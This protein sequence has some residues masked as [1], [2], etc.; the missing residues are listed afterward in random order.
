[1]GLNH[2]HFARV[3]A[4]QCLRLQPAIVKNQGLDPWGPTS[5]WIWWFLRQL[6]FGG[7]LL[8]DFGWGGL[9][10]L[11]AFFEVCFCFVDQ[12]WHVETFFTTI[13]V[14]PT[15]FGLLVV[16][17]LF[18][19]WWFCRSFELITSFWLV[20]GCARRKIEV[21]RVYLHWLLVATQWL[22]MVIFIWVVEGLNFFRLLGRARVRPV[23]IISRGLHGLGSRLCA[24]LL[25]RSSGGSFHRSSF[26]WKRC[27]NYID[28]WVDWAFSTHRCLVELGL[29]RSLLGV[30]SP[31][32]LSLLL[33]STKS[34]CLIV[35]EACWVLPLRLVSSLVLNLIVVRGG[36]DPK[37][38]LFSLKYLVIGSLMRFVTLVQETVSLHW[39]VWLVHQIVKVVAA[40]PN[41]VLGCFGSRSFLLFYSFLFLNIIEQII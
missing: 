6:S 7:R 21:S 29:I 17:R 37:Q 13:R 30:T 1:M 14:K 35:V 40:L 34:W 2:H 36:L 31:R 32:S 16:V 41:G 5:C 27:F 11:F 19:V 9:L 23:E 33:Y 20:K 18:T 12:S 3:V 39:A 4:W 38:W 10:F 22:T 28:T 24:I 26:P 8:R 15:L 25:A